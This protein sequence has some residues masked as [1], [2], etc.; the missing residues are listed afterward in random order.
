MCSRTSLIIDCKEI[1]GRERGSS[2]RGR[3]G[4]AHDGNDDE[5]DGSESERERE[6][7]VFERSR[8]CIGWK[9]VVNCEED[10]WRVGISGLTVLWHVLA[11]SNSKWCIC[12][13]VHC[14]H[15]YYAVITKRK[16]GLVVSINDEN[17][18][19]SLRIIQSV[20]GI[21]W[22]RNKDFYKNGNRTIQ[23]PEKYVAP[24]P[25]SLDSLI[26]CSRFYLTWTWYWISSMN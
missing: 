23:N 18:I 15:L 6:Q 16:L 10:V 9:P 8:R 2:R 3:G 19:Q 17:V 21:S 5:R 22:V 14:F 12:G 25:I 20:N 4:V 7:D 13:I 11:W 24:F 1:G 26:C